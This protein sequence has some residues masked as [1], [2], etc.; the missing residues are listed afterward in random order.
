MTKT[1]WCLIG[2]GKVVLKN[3]TTPFSNKQ[4][5]IVGICTTNINNSINAK[6]KLKLKKCKCYDDVI[7]MLNEVECD[8][9]YICT[10]P[11]YHYI[12]LKIVAKYN[13]PTYVEKPFTLNMKEAKEIVDIYNKENTKLFVAHYKRLTKRTQKLKHILKK[14]YIGE[15]IEIKG[16]FKRYFSNDLLMNSWIYKK[17]ISGGGRF[18][19]ISPHIFDILYYLFG[20]F[21]NIKSKVKYEKI[22]HSCENEVNVSFNIDEINCQLEFNLNSN[23]DEDILLIK[24]TNGYI[25]TSINREMPIYIYNNND[26]LI[27]IYRFK[28]TKT[29]GIESIKEINKI[30]KNKNY[31]SDICTKEEALIIQTYINKILKK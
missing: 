1:K 9:I 5:E 10:P 14:K 18:F 28:K 15:L 21:E 23:V 17:E 13:I 26:K 11:K 16:S 2:C 3:K 30:L 25:K 12:Y 20:E 27:K 29:W 22:K 7:K 31:S 4:N 19:D 24:G 6:N 8:A